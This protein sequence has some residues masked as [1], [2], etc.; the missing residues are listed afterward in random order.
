MNFSAISADDVMAFSALATMVIALAALVF[1]WKQV[2]EARLT[3]DAASAPFVA[4]SIEQSRH[5]QSILN[6][7]IA[8]TGATLARDVML[9]FSPPL[10]SAHWT[11]NPSADP[12][13]AP[14]LTTG[15]P[16][17]PPG[18]RL[19]RVFEHAID[20][21]PQL[22]DDGFPWR[23]DVTVTYCDYRG[24]PQDPLRYVIDFRPLA[25]GSYL[26]VLTEHHAAKALREIRDLLK[27]R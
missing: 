15:F 9:E 3:R 25:D 22:E 19:E 16:S 20:R 7:V 27:K 17:M 23:F 2:T 26:Q 12:S 14:M 4:V 10:T 18:Y 21:N 11:K 5:E 6:L 8:N 1:A 24:R 13:S